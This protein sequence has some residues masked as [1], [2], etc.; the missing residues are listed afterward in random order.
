MNENTFSF[1]RLIVQSPSA[2]LQKVTLLAGYSHAV[3]TTTGLSSGIFHNCKDCELQTVSD[4]GNIGSGYNGN[5][6]ANSV[7]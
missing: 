6:T 2:R 1:K 7:S 3:N 4:V 5:R